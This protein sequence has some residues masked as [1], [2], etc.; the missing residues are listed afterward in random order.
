[1]SRGLKLHELEILKVQNTSKPDLST[2]LEYTVRILLF[3]S[4]G[5]LLIS[6]TLSTDLKLKYVLCWGFFFFD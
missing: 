5:F 4:T 1:M 3:S 2:V 6:S